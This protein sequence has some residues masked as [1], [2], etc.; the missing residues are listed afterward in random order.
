MEQCDLQEIRGLSVYENLEVLIVHCT[1]DVLGYGKAMFA[2][3]TT[4]SVAS[5]SV[6]AIAR[7]DRRDILAKKCRNSAF[8]SRRALQDLVILP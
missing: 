1:G 2:D 6:W 8:N 7:A 4:L 3:R 5:L